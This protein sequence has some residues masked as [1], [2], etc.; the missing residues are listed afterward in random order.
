MTLGDLIRDIRVSL[1]QSRQSF[2]HNLLVTPRTV[3]SWECNQRTPI[4]TVA[5]TLEALDPEGPE[6]MQALYPWTKLDSWARVAL[7]HIV[8]QP[9]VWTY[10][11]MR[12]HL[13]I[14]RRQMNYAV[15]CLHER[16][17][18][19]RGCPYTPT[20]RGI[21]HIDHITRRAA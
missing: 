7:R 5:R 15:R 21:R 14:P 1:G 10:G 16:R 4:V 19:T 6:R 3:Q 9:D 2:A 18:I 12:R 13:G 8:H 17:L 20:A 11:A